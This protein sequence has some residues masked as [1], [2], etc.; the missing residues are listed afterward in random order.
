MTDAP[1]IY[2]TFRCRDADAMIAFLTRAF[3][4]AEH[5]VHRDGDVV[6]HAELTFRG[7]MV[8]LGQD[9][10]DAFAG[11]AGRVGPP[12][13]RAIY[14]A[15]EDP[16]ALCARAEVAGAEIVQPLADKSYGSRDFTARD[17]EGNIWSFGTYRPG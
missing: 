12:A 14:I 9:R 2:P 1:R 7:G 8:M 10:D 5:A 4:F 16:D 11:I 13:G 17:P 3:G 15:V 6:A